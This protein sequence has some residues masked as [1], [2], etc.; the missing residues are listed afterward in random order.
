MRQIVR[1]KPSRLAVVL[2]AMLIGCT[3]GSHSS[4]LPASHRHLTSTTTAALPSR[5]LGWRTASFNEVVTVQYPSGWHVADYGGVGSSAEAPLIAISNLPIGHASTSPSPG[6]PS[7]S[8]A[9]VSVIVSDVGNDG[10]PFHPNTTVDGRPA[11]LDVNSAVFGCAKQLRSSES[12]SA[13]IVRDAS[14][15]IGVSACLPTT[16]ARATVIAIVHSLRP[17]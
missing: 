3:G 17:S 10:L 16:D 8:P 12:I 7:F 15:F 1:M 2:T 4:G 11:Q 6:S 9:A 5:H 14:D 13:L